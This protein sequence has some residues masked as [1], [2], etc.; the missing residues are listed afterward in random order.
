MIFEE[1]LGEEV[2][3]WYF[4]ILIISTQQISDC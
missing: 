2:F 1:I 3:I 4:F